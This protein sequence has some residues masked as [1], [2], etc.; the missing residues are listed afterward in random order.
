VGGGG[1][2][3]LGGWGG[4][5]GGGGLGALWG[6]VKWGVC[7]RAWWG[8]QRSFGGGW[9][10]GNRVWSSAGKPLLGFRIHYARREVKEIV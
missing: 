1:G 9:N 7:R 5:W 4:V 6:G 3:A 10:G 8:W 2:V